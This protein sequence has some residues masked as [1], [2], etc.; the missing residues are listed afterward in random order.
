MGIGVGDRFPAVEVLSVEGPVDMARLWSQ[1]PVVVAFHRMWCPFCQQAAIQLTDVAAELE[2]LGAVVVIVYREELA[3]VA[4]ACEERGT[5]AFCVSDQHRSLEDAVGLGRF[6]LSR[7]V[8]FSPAGC[9]RPGRLEPKWEE[10][11][12][13]CCR[14]AAPMS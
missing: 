7:Y 3:K 12:A 8:A 2:R 9:G 13:T 14:V 11:A 6:N 5:S 1:G 4:D 10:W